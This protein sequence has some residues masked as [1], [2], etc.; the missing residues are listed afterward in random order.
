M[1]KILLVEDNIDMATN[2][3]DMLRHENHVVDIAHTAQDACLNLKTWSYDAIVLDLTLPDGSGYEV[4]QTYRMSGGDA[5]VLILT[6]R[7]T[8]V[9]KTTGFEEGCDDYLTKPFHMK[10]L[11]VRLVALLRRP[12]QIV[13]AVINFADISVNSST[14]TVTKSGIRVELTPIEFQFLEFLVKHQNQSFSSDA[15]FK[16]IWK[17]ESSST[18]EAV[19]TVVKRLRKK[20]DPDGKYL[21]T[22]H[23]VGYILRV[24]PD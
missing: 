20:L 16:R 17:S 19:K 14:F 4:L 11:M 24:E 3:K 2:V 6:G 8:I 5:P 1:A 15:L 21:Q 22:I 18:N 12:R 10:E 23:G 13:P 7:N 9:D